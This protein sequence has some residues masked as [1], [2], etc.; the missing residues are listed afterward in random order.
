MSEKSVAQTNISPGKGICL[1]PN[2][3]TQQGFYR[4]ISP[5]KYADVMFMKCDDILFAR[6]NER[7]LRR[8]IMVVKIWPC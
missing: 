3:L 5:S 8:K 7:F 6:F 2:K 1:V 4:N